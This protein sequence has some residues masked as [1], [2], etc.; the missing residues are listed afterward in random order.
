MDVGV[1]EEAAFISLDLSILNS[2][3]LITPVVQNYH[4]DI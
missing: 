2:F 4:N 1:H 3:I